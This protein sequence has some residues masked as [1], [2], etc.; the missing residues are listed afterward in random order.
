MSRYSSRYLRYFRLKR[1]QPFIRKSTFFF[2]GFWILS[3]KVFISLRLVKR[4]EQKDNL[5]F[6]EI[7]TKK[8]NK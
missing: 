4:E 8:K 6:F 3:G 2:F 1:I 5:I 7:H